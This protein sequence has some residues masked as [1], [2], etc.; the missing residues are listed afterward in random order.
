MDV[1]SYPK[2]RGPCSG[3]PGIRGSGAK[4]GQGGRESSRDVSGDWLPGN[5]LVACKGK[6]DWDRILGWVQKQTT[7]SPTEMLSRR[8]IIGM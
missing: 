4:M 8:V 7:H 3:F 5:D 1:R 6:N 2:S